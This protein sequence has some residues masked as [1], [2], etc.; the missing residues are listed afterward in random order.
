MPEL[1]LLLQLVST[2]T[3]VGVIWFV[4]IVHYPLFGL[5]GTS[6]F[7]RYEQVHQNRTTRVVAPL[8]LIE[9]VTAVA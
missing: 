6:D 1:I 5:V 8:M 7:G 4:Q 9:A 3:M 2:L